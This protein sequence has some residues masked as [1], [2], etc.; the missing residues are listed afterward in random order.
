[1]LAHGT[2]SCLSNVW[3]AKTLVYIYLYIGCCPF[4]GGGK[5]VQSEAFKKAFL[6]TFSNMLAL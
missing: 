3:Y 6:H 2:E 4:R 5:I 1:M